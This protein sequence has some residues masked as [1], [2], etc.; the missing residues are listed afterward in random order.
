MIWVQGDGPGQEYSSNWGLIKVHSDKSISSSE[1][2]SQRSSESSS[3]WQLTWKRLRISSNLFL[4]SSNGS[5]LMSNK[6]KDCAAEVSWPSEFNNFKMAAESEVIP[7]ST[8]SS[9]IYD[10]SVWIHW[11]KL[12]SLI[13]FSRTRPF[14]IA[15]CNRSR[16][17]SLK[18][19]EEQQ[20]SWWVQQSYKAQPA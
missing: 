7:A 10:F 15:R 19:C 9:E 1:S 13:G 3:K 16:S 8:P 11:L 20:Q 2:S 14:V 4:C 17:V 18:N 6:L 5:F 12:W